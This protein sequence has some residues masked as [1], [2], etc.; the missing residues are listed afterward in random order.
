MAFRELVP[1]LLRF[2]AGTLDAA[3]VEQARARLVALGPAVLQQTIRGML[4]PV[5]GYG[6]LATRCVT[7]CSIFF[8]ILV[9]A[10][11]LAVDEPDATGQ[12]VA[13]VAATEC[14]R[15]VEWHVR[16]A[17]DEWLD[18]EEYTRMLAHLLAV[19][20]RSTSARTA[21]A[22]AAR[23]LYA[24]AWLVRGGH[25]AQGE[26]ALELAQHLLACGVS[27]SVPAAPRRALCE[28]R[29]LRRYCCVVCRRFDARVRVCGRCHDTRRSLRC[30]A[31]H[32]ACSAAARAAV[33]LVIAETRVS[34]YCGRE[35]QLV[36]YRR[37]GHREPCRLLRQHAAATLA[38]TAMLDARGAAG[39]AERQLNAASFAA[40]AYGT[41]G[42]GGV[43]E[44]DLARMRAFLAASER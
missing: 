11:T 22:T 1:Y 30:A 26:M 44:A 24:V 21:P 14:A 23:V 41:L 39:F 27:C 42:P 38:Q 33:A 5:G 40:V 9:L 3:G 32:L 17:P 36:D 6:E 34:S 43:G 16:G 4:A 8:D 29:A 15:H 7:V 19:V 31:R 10:P 12:T 35:C 2:R 28:V 20:K 37:H 13:D 25:R 18:G